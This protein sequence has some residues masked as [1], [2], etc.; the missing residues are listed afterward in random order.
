MTIISGRYTHIKCVGVTIIPGR[1][2][3]YMHKGYTQIME[4]A[5]CVAEIPTFHLTPLI[6]LY[7]TH[8]LYTSDR[9]ADTAS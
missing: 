1:Y 9:E 8:L 7:N 5:L 6:L 3:V 2:T 4:R